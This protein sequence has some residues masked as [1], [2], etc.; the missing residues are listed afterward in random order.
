MDEAKWAACRDPAHMLNL[1]CGTARANRK[2]PR[3]FTRAS[4][5]KLRLFAVACCRHLWPLIA[6]R[7][8]RHAVE[9]A[10]R[11]A[12][13]QARKTQLQA[14]WSA[15]YD[16]A[17]GSPDDAI[18]AAAEAANPSSDSAAR[19]T[20]LVV[21]RAAPYLAGR[22]VQVVLLRDLFGNPFRPLTVEPTWR[23]TLVLQLAEAAYDERVLPSG[24]LH[25]DR[26]AVLA[27]AL[28]D[29]GCDHAGMLEHLRGPGPHVRGCHVLDAI[30]ERE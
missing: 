18:W 26:L 29:Q 23:T 20:A 22:P 11:Y 1:L 12:D 27:D 4:E 15:A 8:S 5:R 30:L 14:A 25:A 3:F 9:V 24:E 6:L 16:L 17:S 2:R 21:A 13:G 10:E 28:E 19:Q 7:P